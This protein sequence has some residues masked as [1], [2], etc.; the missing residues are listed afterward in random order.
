MTK[1]RTS[2]KW[3][4]LI[5]YLHKTK[6]NIVVLISKRKKKVVYKTFSSRKKV[7]GDKI[8]FHLTEYGQQ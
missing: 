2:D 5:V 8:F 7:V 1:E 3:L 4:D 6:R